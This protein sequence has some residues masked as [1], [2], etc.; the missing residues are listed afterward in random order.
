MR[1][2][3]EDVTGRVERA[4]RAGD[5]PAIVGLCGERDLFLSDYDYLCHRLCAVAFEHRASTYARKI[6]ARRWVFAVPQV[7]HYGDDA[8]EARPLFTGPVEPDEQEAILWMSFDVEDGVDYGRVLFARRPSGEPVFDSAQYLDGPAL[9]TT[10][11]PGNVLLRLLTG[12]HD[13]DG[14]STEPPVPAH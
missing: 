12:D 9:P 11:T 4:V 3:V 1:K 7:W 2:L 13:E 6:A 5:C 10:D 14:Q 8:I